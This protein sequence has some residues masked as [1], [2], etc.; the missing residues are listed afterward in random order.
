MKKLKKV[1]FSFSI[2]VLVCALSLSS[3]KTLLAPEYDK[4][5][6]ETITTSSEKTM[7]FISEISE[8]TCNTDYSKREKKYNELIGAY[9]ALKI[10]AKARPLPNNVATK[11]INELLGKKGSPTISGDYPSAFAF[12]KI[13]ETLQKMKETDK[14]TTKC[15]KPGA[16]KA[17]KGQIEIFLDQ[18]I[19]YESFLKR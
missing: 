17:F 6:V 15:I 8:G 19:T 2:L 14:D 11:K 9:D 18:A 4:A 1:K 13:S 16:L 12:E 5:I 10:K 3:C 7:G